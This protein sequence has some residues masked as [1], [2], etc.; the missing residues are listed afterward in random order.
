[1]ALLCAE[2]LCVDAGCSFPAYLVRPP[3]SPLATTLA[4]RGLWFRLQL[5]AQGRWCFTSPWP[6]CASTHLVRAGLLCAFTGKSWHLQ[7]LRC[8]LPRV[9][10]A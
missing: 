3:L 1:M 9:D 5:S 7:L 6:W 2:H 4:A 10:C 8:T